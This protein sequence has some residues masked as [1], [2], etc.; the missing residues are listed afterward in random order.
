MTIYTEVTRFH[1]PSTSRLYEHMPT[2]ADTLTD[3]EKHQYREIYTY[4]VIILLFAV[5]PIGQRQIESKV[6]FSAIARGEES[7][8]VGGKQFSH[9]RKIL[10][11]YI[12]VY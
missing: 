4:A 2:H 10:Y 9:G 5:R 8:V 7:A 1:F 6:Y 11:V 3:T 12:Y